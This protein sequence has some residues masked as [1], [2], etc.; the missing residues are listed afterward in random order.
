MA[1][2]SFFEEH[3]K[4][5]RRGGRDELRRAPA[6]L[7]HQV[8]LDGLDSVL[9]GDKLGL[10]LQGRL[11]PHQCFLKLFHRHVYVA[12]REV[13]DGEVRRDL[14]RHGGHDD[15]VVPELGVVQ[16]VGQADEGHVLH[17]VRSIMEG[18]A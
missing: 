3:E 15:G 2:Y 13:V 12:Q 7:Q 14:H 16:D 4:R 9:G 10:Q 5:D 6:L 18:L 11:V 17:L 1:S 8:T